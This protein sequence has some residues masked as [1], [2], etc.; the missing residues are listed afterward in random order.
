MR[1][2]AAISQGFRTCLKLDATS[3]RQKLHR[4]AATKIAQSVAVF[5]LRNIKNKYDGN[6]KD[7]Y[8]YCYCTMSN[9]YRQTFSSFYAETLICDFLVRAQVGF[10]GRSLISCHRVSSVT[11]IYTRVNCP[12]LDSSLQGVVIT[13]EHKSKCCLRRRTCFLWFVA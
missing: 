4:V 6:L 7:C 11:D 10:N 8:C 12:T 9:C 1:F 3:A 13:L 2:V 5:F